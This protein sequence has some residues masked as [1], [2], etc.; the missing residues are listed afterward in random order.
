MPSLGWFVRSR[1]LY[2]FSH[3][4][5]SGTSPLNERKQILEG[6]PVSTEPWLWE[7]GYLLVILFS[8]Q[9]YRTMDEF[10]TMV[11]HH[12]VGRCECMLHVFFPIIERTRSNSLR[13]VQVFSYDMFLELKELF[14]DVWSITASLFWMFRVVFVWVFL[15]YQQLSGCWI[16]MSIAQNFGYLL[17]IGDYTTQLY[18]DFNKVVSEARRVQKPKT[19]IIKKSIGFEY[20]VII[21]KNTGLWEKMWQHPVLRLR[22]VYEPSQKSKHVY[23]GV[24]WWFSYHISLLFVTLL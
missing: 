2:P 11:F 22:N 13:W 1:D 24:E 14:Q 4:H 10:I 17:Y 3:D 9:L 5:G 18:R 7:E 23:F 8:W 16:Y 12:L 6:D 15:I 21:S 20:N 19:Y